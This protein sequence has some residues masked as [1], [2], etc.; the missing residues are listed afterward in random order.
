MA[1]VQSSTV[2]GPKTIGWD[3]ER[4]VQTRND[5]IVRQAY[6]QATAQGL[7]ESTELTPSEVVSIKAQMAKSTH[8]GDRVVDMG[9]GWT[10]MQF[11]NKVFLLGDKFSFSIKGF[12]FPALPMATPR[13]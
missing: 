6:R 13:F 12:Q 11:D 1:E 5:N 10:L 3:N 4:G 7:I 9:A 8:V 2:Q